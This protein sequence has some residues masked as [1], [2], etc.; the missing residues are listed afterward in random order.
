MS[1]WYIHNF[2]ALAL[3]GCS[4]ALCVLLCI[5]QGTRN[6]TCTCKCLR[7]LFPALEYWVGRGLVHLFIGLQMEGTNSEGMD[8]ATRDLTNVASMAVSAM[9]IF[10]IAGAFMCFGPLERR[11]QR[12]A[13]RKEEVMRESEWQWRWPSLLRLSVS[14]LSLS[15]WALPQD[16]NQAAGLA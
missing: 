2:A 10:F 6:T 5:E 15:I 8:T 3:R 14:L 13:V 12:L 7:Q 1:C 9:G 4:L 11:G 16:L